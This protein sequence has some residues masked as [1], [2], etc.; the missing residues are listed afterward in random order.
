MRRGRK[1][2]SWEEVRVAVRDHECAYCDNAIN[3]GDEYRRAVSAYGSTFEI[4]K[5][6]EYPDCQYNGSR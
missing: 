4:E 1:I 3:Y 2:P 6:H 5:R